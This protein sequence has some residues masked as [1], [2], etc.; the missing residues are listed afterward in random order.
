MCTAGNYCQT[1]ATG[2]V[3]C[4]D[5]YYSLDGYTVCMQC[6]PGHECSNKAILPVPCA[7]GEV[8]EPGSIACDTCAAGEVA[9]SAAMCG[10][11]D[12]GWTSFGGNGVRC[13]I[14]PPTFEVDDNTAQPVECTG[15]T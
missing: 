5:G 14:S 2:E 12:T 6:P 15:E 11:C 3:A 13:V 10:E 1:P 7:E 4:P 8:A 9:Q